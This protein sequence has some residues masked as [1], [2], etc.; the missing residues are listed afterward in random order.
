MVSLQEALELVKKA[1]ALDNA[2]RTQEA[3]SMY[4]LAIE[5]LRQVI[6]T[7]KDQ[8]TRDLIVSKIQ[9][10]T[11]RVDYLRATINLN[12]NAPATS[13][14]TATPPP[15]LSTPPPFAFP[16]PPPFNN[17]TS[18]QQH[19]TPPQSKDQLIQSALSLANMAVK[20]EAENRISDSITCYNGCAELLDQAS[21]LESDIETRLML[22]QKKQEYSNRAEE[23]SLKVRSNSP[24]NFNSSS[25][26]SMDLPFPQVAGGGNDMMSSYNNI[27]LSASSSE[28]IDMAIN[29]TQ[30]AVKE[31]DVHNYSKAI[32]LY[33]QSVFYFNAA[34]QVESNEKVRVL[35]GEKMTNSRI[36]CEFLK[37]KINYQSSQDSTINNIPFAMKPGGKYKDPVRKKTVMERLVKTIRGPKNIS[38]HWL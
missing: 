22:N 31:D 5:H 21:T 1:V 27:E 4:S 28:Y 11:K 9:E 18:P 35:I 34:L 10:Y 23:L 12:N 7:A 20:A 37:N 13:I 25:S 17:N 32:P 26:S 14:S 36:R 6:D 8:Q 3:V 15:I 29:Y 33:E 19:H 38:D 16:T 30:E 2:Q 24:V